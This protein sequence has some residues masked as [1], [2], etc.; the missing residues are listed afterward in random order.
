MGTEWF[1]I[2]KI[3]NGFYLLFFTNKI[4]SAM[5]LVFIFDYSQTSF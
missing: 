5:E 2:C 4:M 3:N 1:C